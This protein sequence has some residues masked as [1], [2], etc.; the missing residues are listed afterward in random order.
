MPGASAKCEICGKTAYPLESVTALEKTY[1][2]FCFKCCVCSSTLNLK[3][4]KGFE[5]KIYCLTHTP[6]VKATSVTDTVAMKHALNTPKKP[7]QQGI[8]KAD[9]KVAPNKSKDFSVNVTGDQST[10][11]APESSSITYT[12]H[13]GDQS[14]ENAP[15]SSSIS[16]DAHH[17]DQSTENAPESSAITYDA[18][19]GDQST[20]NAPDDSA[21]TYESGNADQSTD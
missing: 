15:E 17:G 14:T 3:N 13:H 16:Y 18:H 8:H 5:G 7:I 11:N 21:I 19:H 9:P 1:H 20:E 2:K 4:F 10:E 12:A 6:K